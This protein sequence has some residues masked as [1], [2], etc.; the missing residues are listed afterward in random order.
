ME[1]HRPSSL[2]E[3]LLNLI[4]NQLRFS[5]YN[6][7][8][9]MSIVAYMI[10]RHIP[11]QP[12]IWGGWLFLVITSQ[13]YRAK[14][15]SKLPAQKH[16]PVEVRTRQAARINFACTFIQSL[17]FLAFPILTPFEAAVMSM[18]F[19]GLGVGSIVTAV[20]WPPYSLAHIGISLVPLFGLWAWSGV[21][22][23]AGTLGIL[24]ALIGLSY[25][26]SMWSISKRLYGMNQEFFSNREKLA[27]ALD[28][29]EAAG[30]A[31]T[32]FLAAASHDLRQPIHTLS[33][34]SAA[35]GLK[36]LDEATHHLAENI[37]E[38]VN[39]LSS[40]LDALLDVSKLDA[41]IVPV[42]PGQVNLRKLLLR[43]TEE[44]QEMAEKAGI[45][46][47]VNCPGGTIA[48]TDQSLLERII[49]NIYTNA[50]V[51]TANCVLT[52]DVKLV[53]DYWELHIADTGSGIPASEHKYIF[54][55]FYQVDNP[56]RDRSKGIGLGL[57]IV[58]RLAKLLELDMKFESAPDSGTH[59][60]FFIPVAD[61]SA[62]SRKEPEEAQASLLGL[63]ILVVDDEPA[64]REG[65]N[66]LLS[67]LGCRVT[68]THDTPTA[69]EFARNEAPDIALVDYRLAH[70]ESGLDTI[71]GL[72]EIYPD[73]PA[74]I[75]SGDTGPDRLREANEAAITLLSKPVAMDALREAIAEACRE[76]T[77]PKA[78][79]AGD[80][81]R[82]S[83]NN[84]ANT[85]IRTAR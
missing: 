33:L 64:V 47:V 67:A 29:A 79:I 5:P 42:I 81:S 18:M 39:A 50:I 49:R 36:N 28:E 70:G 52:A 32:R 10:Y 72:R 55:E 82:G 60:T 71:N 45:S 85:G 6:M 58:A 17:C 30:L 69:L 80:R 27:T 22:G 73:L 34:F 25:S 3:E 56:G 75:I 8:F 24:V 78:I 51:H 74:I 63:K 31:K 14:R 53:D 4:A 11:E 20:G 37:D 2:D 84:S 26:A 7:V 19:L 40:Q 41:G 68:A 1:K 46:L 83:S 9:S 54:E 62:I 13:V 77:K 21:Y 16:I 38:A 35:L 61:T 66:V 65:M 15:L 12:W 48:R 57:S 43:L 59:F 23:S 44:H 76:K